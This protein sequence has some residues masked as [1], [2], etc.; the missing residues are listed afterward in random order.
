MLSLFCYFM[1]TVNSYGH[2]MTVN[3]LFCYFKPMVNSYVHVRT[4]NP[5]TI[6]GQLRPPKPLSS[7]KCTYFSHEQTTALLESADGEM[8]ISK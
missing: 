2:V 5:N 6:S 8:K 7:T 1:S 4:V 3:L